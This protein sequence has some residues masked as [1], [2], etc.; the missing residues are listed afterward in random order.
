MIDKSHSLSAF[1]KTSDVLMS[2]NETV[3]QSNTP[4][5]AKLRAG[6]ICAIESSYIHI[7][8][9]ERSKSAFENIEYVICAPSDMSAS[10]YFNWTTILA[11][12]CALMSVHC[13]RFRSSLS[14]DMQLYLSRVK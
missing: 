6:Q 1:P 11:T 10:F 9:E 13:Y 2:I 12:P 14:C 3:V 7:L 4:R 5:F 8:A